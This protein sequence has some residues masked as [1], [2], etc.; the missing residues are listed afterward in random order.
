VLHMVCLQVLPADMSLEETAMFYARAGAAAADAAI[1][2]YRVSLL[3]APPSLCSSEIQS[4]SF[5]FL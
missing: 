5:G 4:H 2:T 1:V 3:T